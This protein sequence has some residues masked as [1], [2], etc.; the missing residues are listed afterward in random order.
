MAYLA[1]VIKLKLH[2]Q[3]NT[4]SNSED[5]ID[6]DDDPP[7][8]TQETRALEPR[9]KKSRLAEL[10]SIVNN[11]KEMKNDLSKEDKSDDEFDIFGKYIATQLRKL[12]TEQAILDQEAIQKVVTK[13]RLQDL[14]NKN[15]K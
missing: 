11:M 8:S 9:K 13:C 15:T 3:E 4:D 7:A 2:F 5:R 14:Q 10:S 1:P 12:S 6:G